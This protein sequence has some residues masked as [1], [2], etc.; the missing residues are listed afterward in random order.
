MKIGD[1]VSVI[2]EDLKGKVTSVNG[3]T[4]EILDQ[5]RDQRA[6]D[7]VDEL[8]ALII[9]HFMVIE[10]CRPLML[11]IAEAR[12]AAAEHPHRAGSGHF[13]RNQVDALL[14]PPGV[15]VRG[16]LEQIQRARW[17]IA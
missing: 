13:G 2:D 9:E 15:V 11:G 17:K 12:V 7:F 4:M 5:L 3:N 1:Q 8:R 14:L 10:R 6:L 16:L